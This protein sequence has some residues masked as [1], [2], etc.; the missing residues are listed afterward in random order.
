MSRKAIF[1]DRDGVINYPILKK[2]KPY[3]PRKLDEVKIYPEVY[4]FLEIM[5]NSGF[6]LIVITNQPDVARGDILKSQVE[7]I[8]DYLLKTLLWITLKFVI[9]MIQIIVSV[10]KPRPGSLI[11]AAKLYNLKLEKSYMIGDRWKD[12]SAGLKAGCKTIFID[13]NYD[14]KKPEKY[15]VKI[16]NLD[17]ARDYINKDIK[18][19]L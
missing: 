6:Y 17:E 18:E 10:E 19:T 7:E 9:M 4:S 3:P 5:K 11:S 8:N 1:L 14:E 2:G 16:N 15:H 12:I 13:R